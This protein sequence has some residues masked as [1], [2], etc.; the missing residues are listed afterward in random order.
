M[1][2]YKIVNPPNVGNLYEI[3]PDGK[4]SIPAALRGMYTSPVEAERAITKYEAT[5]E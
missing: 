4:G 3:K 5:K 1:S 2:K